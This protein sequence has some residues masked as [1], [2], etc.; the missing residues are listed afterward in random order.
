M[1]YYVLNLALVY[2]SYIVNINIDEFY[3]EDR[4]ILTDSFQI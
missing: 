3:L 4:F 2:L 1:K